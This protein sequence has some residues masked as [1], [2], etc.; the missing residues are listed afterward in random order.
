MSSKFPIWLRPFLIAALLFLMVGQTSRVYA[1]G[2]STSQLIGA[3]NAAASGD[4]I[5]LA[6]SCAYTFTAAYGSNGA[7]LP[8][9]DITLTINGNAATI[10]R[11]TAS[12]TPDFRLF[13]VVSGGS[14]TLNNAGVING[15]GS[16]AALSS[17]SVAA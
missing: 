7:A 3:I 1:I 15:S 5:T 16:T 9:I 12:G 6:A 14:L 10:Q 2:C 17:S 13:N 8:D 4:T 11:S